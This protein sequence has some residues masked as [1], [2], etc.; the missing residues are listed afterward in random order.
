MPA[1]SPTMEKGTIAKWYKKEGDAIKAG[2]VIADVETDK[3]T[4]AFEATEPGILVC[5][6]S[7]FPLCLLCARLICCVDVQAKVL[8][9]Q[10]KEVPLGAIV[11]VLVDEPSSVAAFK[12]FTLDVCISHFCTCRC[13]R[14]TPHFLCLTYYRALLRLLRPPLPNRPP[15]PLRPRLPPPRPRPLRPPPLPPRPRHRRVT[16]K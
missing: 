12:N 3:A 5:G 14:M 8:V 15:P 1:L 13:K 11:A 4:V 7:L 6:L 2:D 16:A 9:A 10:G